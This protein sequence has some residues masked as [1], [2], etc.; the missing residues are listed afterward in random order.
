M[1]EF[2]RPLDLSNN[3]DSWQWELADLGGYS[4]SITRLHIDNVYLA[5][6][7]L[8]AVWLKDLPRKINIFLWSVAQD[9]LP[10]RLNLS[11]RG[12]EI[13]QISCVSG[14]FMSES[15]QHL[16]FECVVA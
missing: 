6:S 16:L 8:R 12:I 4:V 5:A 9:R 2:I 7:D 1:V 11:R 10:T 13:E 3:L 15:L 14:C